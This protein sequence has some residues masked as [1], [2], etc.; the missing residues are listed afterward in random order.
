MKPFRKGANLNR[1]HGFLETRSAHF[2]KNRSLR[3]E[4]KFCLDCTIGR[5]SYLFLRILIALAFLAPT[6]LAQQP[7][8]Q[9]PVPTPAESQTDKPK[10]AKD[11]QDKK[12]PDDQIGK[13]KL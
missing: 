7:Q 5:P 4:L 3:R 12:T 11:D 6:A 10:E 13:S 2:R 9:P 8:Q 1:E